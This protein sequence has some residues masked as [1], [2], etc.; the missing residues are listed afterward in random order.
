M[1]S[2]AQLNR[3]PKEEAARMARPDQDRLARSLMLAQNANIIMNIEKR[4][5]EHLMKDLRVHIV[6]N[7]DGEQSIIVLQKRLDIMR[8]Y[9]SLAD[10]DTDSYEAKTA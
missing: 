7:R 9:D 8:L 4:K 3:P 5:D 2:P 1:I 10:W 6:K